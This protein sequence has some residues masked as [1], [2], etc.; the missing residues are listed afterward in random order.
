MSEDELLDAVR[1]VDGVVCTLTD[2]ITAAVLEP[3]PENA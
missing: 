3:E 1:R 2:R